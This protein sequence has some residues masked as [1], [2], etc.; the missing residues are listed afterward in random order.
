MPSDPEVMRALKERQFKGE[1]YRRD[2]RAR[3]E[4]GEAKLSD[5]ILSYPD[6]LGRK[7][8]F[9]LVQMIPGVSRG[10]AMMYARSVGADSNRYLEE[11]TPSQRANLHKR[12][13]R[14][15]R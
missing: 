1:A 12:L 9:R 2:L 15:G 3:I 10:K 4:R 13:R 7:T 6:E 5:Y 8:I 14:D 11:L